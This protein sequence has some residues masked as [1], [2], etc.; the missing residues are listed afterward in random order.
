MVVTYPSPQTAGLHKPAITIPKI[1]IIG[2]GNVGASLARS[3]L[4][5]N[6]G[7]VVLLDIVAGRPQGLAL[8]MAEA[9][10]LEG[11]THHILGTNDYQDTAGSQVIVITAGLPRKPGMSRDDLLKVNGRIILDVVAKALPQ[12]PDAHFILVTNPLDVMTY[13]TWQASGLP[14]S[15]VMGQAGV[16]DSARFRTFIAHE[17]GVPPHDVSTMVL[18]GHGDLMVPLISHTTVSSIPLTELLPTAKIQSLVDRT[19][20][21]GAEIVNHLK[22]GGAYYAPAAATATMVAAILQN[23]SAILPVSAYLDGQ[24][25]LQDIYLGVPCRLDSNGAASVVELSLTADEQ[26]ALEASAQSVRHTLEKALPMFEI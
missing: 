3:L 20:H 14:P 24:Y 1:T 26:A 18:G 16:L 17:L 25:G 11:C 12:S 6:L 10:P 2:A 9:C 5:Q 15:R 13:L 4:S 23:Q 21:G 19:R 7:N 22:T 8:D